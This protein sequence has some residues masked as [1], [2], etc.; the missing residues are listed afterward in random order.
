[1][2]HDQLLP[3]SFSGVAIITRMD[4]VTETKVTE[5]FKDQDG[6]AMIVELERRGDR[7]SV[8]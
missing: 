6:R 5:L 3:Q 8:V 4:P 2:S 1:M 7:K